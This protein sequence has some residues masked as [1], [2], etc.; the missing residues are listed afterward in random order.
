MEKDFTT[1]LIGN[2]LGMAID[3]EYFSIEAGLKNAWQSLDPNTQD[4]IKKLITDGD[5]LTTENQLDK[6]YEAIQACLTLKRLENKELKWLH[7]DAREFPTQFHHFIKKTALHFFC[8]PENNNEKLNK[9][10]SNL[11]N[12]IGRNHVHLITLNYDK[13]LY[14]HFIDDKEIM[15]GYDGKLVDGFH[16]THTGFDPDHLV[17]QYERKF[18]FYLHL[19]GSPLF[20]TDTNTG[21]INKSLL[22]S[23]SSL[24][25]DDNNCF[26]EHLILCNTN[27]KP[28]RI[29]QSPLLYSYWRYFNL[30]LKES[31]RIVLFGYSGNDNHVNEEISKTSSGKEI[32]IVEH[33]DPSYTLA[34][35]EEYW[36]GKIALGIIKLIRC[37]SVLEHQF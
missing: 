11:S 16:T 4:K 27:L 2:G 9:F 35:K 10:I 18:G 21:L 7:D 23:S 29:S 30:A 5:E 28:T 1:I 33:E 14:S 20:Y 19:H 36:K 37:N 12:F 6:H 13:L 22:P 24:F 26:R 32:I 3:P 15:N 25:A 31:K 8:Y 17:R 34:K